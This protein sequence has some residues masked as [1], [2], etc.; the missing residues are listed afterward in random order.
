MLVLQMHVSLVENFQVSYLEGGHVCNF[1]VKDKELMKFRTIAV[2]YTLA[3]VH[4]LGG[5]GDQRPRV[6]IRY[7]DRECSRSCTCTVLSSW[8]PRQEVTG[9][10][11]QYLGKGLKVEGVKFRNINT[12][13]L[14]H[15]DQI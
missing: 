14:N 4:V 10:T 3:Y 2:I 9:C 15:K 7:L 11:S 1:T 8:H 5:L 12:I 6:W 13:I